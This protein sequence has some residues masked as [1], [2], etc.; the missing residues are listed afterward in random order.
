MSARTR[1]SRTAGHTPSA[2]ARGQD[3]TVV[4]PD[5]LGSE[6]SRSLA[7][8][9]RSSNDA[10]IAKGLDGTITA[11]NDAATALYG[12]S[13]E[14]M[15]GRNIEV[16]IPPEALLRERE[17]HAEAAA[18]APESG[19]RCV[20][21]RADGSRLRVVMTLSPVRNESGDVVGVASISRA[22]TS[23]E[24]WEA[25]M[26]ALM[27][28]APDGMVFVAP[29]GRIERA[30]AQLSALF[31]YDREELVG[32]GIEL[33]VPE[34]L[35]A[36]HAAHRAD[37]LRDP[38]PRPM[39]TGL[40]LRG[41]RRDGS[42]FPIEVSLAAQQSDG[43]QTLIA[44]V[45]D[46]S[47]QQAVEEALR[48]SESRLRQ[49]AENVETVFAL[50][51]IEP[52]AYL[53]LSPGF[54]TLTGRDPQQVIADPGLATR[55][56]HPDDRPRVAAEL[57]AHR[58]DDGVR[59]SEHR[60]VR[61][62]GTI[63][64]VRT[65]S[66]IVPHPD[67]PPS[68]VVT[69]TEDITERVQSARALADA[70]AA[71][72]AAN[73]AKNEFLSRMS[74]ELRTPL[75]AVLG[76]GQILERRLAGTDNVDAVRHVVRAGRHLLDLIN[77][78]L[79]IA[80]IE[81]GQVS[82]SPEPVSVAAIADETAVLMQPLAAAAD[83]TLT[84]AGG[85]AGCHVLAD[86]QR[87]RQIL[88]NLLSNAVKYNRRGGTAEVS[89]TVSAGLTSIQVRDDGPGI[90]ADLQDRIFVPFDRLGAENSGVE[91]TGVGLTVT[92]GLVEL[93]HGTLTFSSTPGTPTVFTVTLP[94]SSPLRV[95]PPK[96]AEEGAA[97]PPAGTTDAA[98]VLYIEDNEPNVRVMES[99]LEMR[100]GWR[101]IHAA[102]GSL[103]LELARAHHPDLLLLDLHLPDGSGAEVLQAI[104]RDP[105][106]RDLP[107]AVLSADASP[108]QI[109][110]MRAAGAA[111]YLTK[112]LDLD[113]ILAMLDARAAELR[114]RRAGADGAGG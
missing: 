2:P 74:H 112:P 6:P 21:L 95:P 50:R 51:Q 89:W 23:A 113:E 17:R 106:L 5:Q 102:L 12:Y 75:N 48:E 24:L 27:E 96:P 107:V 46:V 47:A 82:L 72:R 29:D 110:R 84:V 35:R 60:I 66:S 53:Y 87:L 90:P 19:Y 78:V 32:A 42:T 109:K 25:R 4:L 68:R 1:T 70:E 55:M 28:A 57:F 26:A 65:V 10:V 92:R 3:H 99:I 7:A 45:R 62:D 56:V 8:A 73:A 16:M 69:A 64:W 37:F 79:D 71:A 39:G 9:V 13:P 49:L 11:W 93:M 103:G 18:G 81:S 67:G 54:R 59:R 86:R 38:R 88:L 94:A 104:R 76:F 97:A 108:H 85:P 30:N 101:L 41:R 114:S 36:G 105:A 80:R 14:E 77:E 111:N 52:V 61:P 100:P 15:L 98:T 20:R 33:L 31:G 63:R 91:G 58:A 83:V 22:L 40:A 43:D 34:E 44:V